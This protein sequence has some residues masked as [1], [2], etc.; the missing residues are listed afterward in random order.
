MS[1]VM[2]P[3][4][5]Q[6]QLGSP[7]R[8]D[9]LFE[10][11]SAATPS[12]TALTVHSPQ[13]LSPSVAV[14]YEQLNKRSAQLAARLRG[15]GIGEGDVVAVCSRRTVGAVVALLGVC[16]TGAAFLPLSPDD[17]PVRVAQTM[18]LAQAQAL[19]IVRPQWEVSPQRELDWPWHDGN[20]RSAVV[21]LDASGE[22]V[23]VSTGYGRQQMP[24]MALEPSTLYVL[25]TSGSTGAP[26]GVAGTHVGVI[27]RC[28]W[29]QKEYPW[30]S[31]DVCGARTPFTFVDS[32][33]EIFGPLIFAPPGCTLHLL[34]DRADGVSLRR[35]VACLGITR[36]LV[37]PALLDSFIDALADAPDDGN[38]LQVISVSGEQL[39]G[40]S[41]QRTRELLPRCLLLN[42]Y[43]STEVSG[44]VT[45]CNVSLLPLECDS[46]LRVPIGLPID[47]CQVLLMDAAGQRITAA[48]V[49]GEV[50]VAGPHVA[51]GYIYD[52]VRTAEQFVHFEGID[53]T[54]FRTG[55][56]AKLRADG[57]FVW[58]GRA[59]RQVQVRGQR[60][61]LEE[62]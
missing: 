4:Q 40:C 21:H 46:S 47:N 61:Q 31:A 29:A 35:W 60:I 16:K 57:Q 14:T 26:H 9:V 43:G 56:Y 37:V 6:G 44:D 33:A 23:A 32:I 8:I 42:L 10:E 51:H 3:L 19:V 41:A 36:L 59:D 58:L 27:N 50:V 53:G 22:T 45:C 11:R 62:V 38:S 34:P 15:V 55:D 7:R 28:I 12:D 13:Q 5:Q 20:V 49:V 52:T 39:S 48:G 2:P 25:F 18:T 17:P 24:T 54:V 1:I 30:T